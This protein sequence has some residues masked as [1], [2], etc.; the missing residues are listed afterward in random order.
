[1]NPNETFHS[2]QHADV[3]SEPA[4]VHARIAQ[5]DWSESTR[6]QVVAH[7][8]DLVSAVRH[9]QSASWMQAM[10]TQYQLSNP[11]GLA[12][13]SLAE[14]I[15]R[16]PDVRTRMALLEDKVLARNWSAHQSQSDSAWVNTATRGLML[17]EQVLDEQRS[18]SVL[19]TLKN[20]MKR[21]GEPVIDVILGQIL[22]QLG[23]QFVLGQ[24]IDLALK[25]A[26]TLE[27]DGYTYSYDMLGEGAKTAADA[28]RYWQSYHD[29]I[30]LIGA[31]CVHEDIAQNPG[32]SIKLSA[33]HPRYEVAQT[34][35][36]LDELVPRVLELA[37]LAAQFNMGL[38]IDAEE[39][40]RL[41]L[42]LLIIEKLMA[43]SGMAK[44]CGLGVV[45]QGYNPRAPEVL[46]HL[47]ALAKQHD[48]EIMVRLVK[49]AYWDAE[50]KRAQVLGL[51]EFPVHT[52]KAFT[53]VA[54]IANAKRLLSMNDKIYAQFA[55]H[56]AH[57]VCAVLRLIADLPSQ[58]RYEFQRL[59]GMGEALHDVAK[60]QNFYRCRIYAPV[61]HHHDL[62]SYL[63]RRLLEN[64]ANGSFVHQIADEH[65]SASVVAQD[66]IARA[67]TLLDEH[68]VGNVRPAAQLYPERANSQGFDLSNSLT[69]ARLQN[70]REAFWRD[71]SA[72]DILDA[73]MLVSHNPAIKDEVVGSV[74]FTLA[75]HIPAMT[76]AALAAQ[77]AWSERSV[78]ER[79]QIIEAIARSFEAQHS[80]LMALLTREA[81]KSWADAVSELREAVD[82]CHYYASQA[83]SLEPHQIHQA[84]GVVVCISP[85]NF[86]LAIFTGQIVANL[87]VGNA[88][89]AKPAELTPM[90]ADCA[91]RFMH[92]AGVPADVLQLAQGKGGEIGQALVAQS[93]IAGV[94]FT[95]SLPTAQRIHQTLAQHAAPDA[96][97]I[98][99]T[100][101]LNAMIVDSTAL[102]EQAVRDIIASGFQ[103]AGQR[104][105][106]LRL[107]YVQA[108]IYD[109]LMEMLK[110][111]M[112]ALVIGDPAD[113]ATDV[114]P[115]IDATA[116]HKLNQYIEQRR[117]RIIHQVP[118]PSAHAHKGYFV[119]PTL[120][121]VD[122]MVDLREEQF[123]PIVHVATFEADQLDW[124]LDEI[125][126]SGYGLTLG[127]HTR[128]ER[129]AHEIAARAQVG[130]I[131]V[132]R[133]Q[134]GAVVGVQPFGGCGLSGTGPKAG[135]ALYLRALSRAV[136]TTE[137]VAPALAWQ[138]QLLDSP[139]GETNAYRVQARGRVLCLGPSIEDVRTQIISA[140]AT[141]NHAIVPHVLLAQTLRQYPEL[142][143]HTHSA[144]ELSD[145]S[146]P[147]F[148]DFDAVAYFAPAEDDARA[149][150]IRVNLAKQAG[151]IVPLIGNAHSVHEWVHEFHVC[152]DTTAAGG[153]AELLAH[154]V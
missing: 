126:A 11:E 94:C 69:L 124:V 24:T 92:A 54:Y 45:V 85:W 102:P 143:E 23:G 35:T 1:M 81:G 132:N 140:S 89:L 38:N 133:N 58:P 154:S 147:A 21:M 93:R 3:S 87:V 144:I 104:C 141:R 84:R 60:R 125:N 110:G 86:P 113:L 9:N 138:A 91:V 149:R 75:E 139:T 77:T 118:V 4:I 37:Q 25:E 148:Y 123:G 50:I 103:S 57:T 55:T 8:T 98:A 49:G 105:S 39:A 106:A 52:R 43:S 17:L 78:D 127:V 31:R 95:G 12:L 66:P 74:P 109:K 47:Y 134:I 83:R 76:D 73:S 128:I 33:L 130:N 36:V 34:Q 129:R 13:M 79:A 18:E 88:V 117:S 15:L 22:K 115:V 151:A 101:G 122:G 99:E 146:V 26:R 82:F 67:Q 71:Y 16:V 10:L 136:Q 145:T 59:H 53:D 41:E 61:G 48:R 65:L 135:G 29:A 32:I 6:A 30:M 28:Q 68:S 80:A 2:L 142:T 107:L 96:L 97:L 108:D 46:D 90:I 62:L 112:D 70:E 42:S 40:E 19:G 114:S 20:L 7:A 121:A 131:Y 116:Q 27:A 5:I 44:W 51:S 150:E 56:N 100:G 64:G 111:A 152:T 14:A 153:N 72:P 63:V 120:M 137:Q 119:P